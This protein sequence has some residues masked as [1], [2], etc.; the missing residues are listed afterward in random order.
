M[1][2]LHEFYSVD[3]ISVYVIKLLGQSMKPFVFR[4]H[5]E[6]FTSSL[7]SICQHDEDYNY[8][9]NGEWLTISTFHESNGYILLLDSIIHKE[10]GCTHVEHDF[11]FNGDVS[12]GENETNYRHDS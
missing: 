3:K 10:D 12:D 4:F 5:R 8:Y 1:R 11:H 7:R 6:V 2:Y 9:H